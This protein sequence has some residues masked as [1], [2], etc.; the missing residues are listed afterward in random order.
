[1]ESTSPFLAIQRLE[2]QVKAI[3]RQVNTDTL[4]APGKKLL[5]TLRRLLVD[6][7]IDIRDYELS[8]TRDEQLGKAEQGKKRLKQLR[9]DILASSDVFGP[10]DVAHITARLEQIEHWLQ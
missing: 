3:L 8:E 7:R 2:L 1:M 5:G 10:A 9:A 6:A 4:D